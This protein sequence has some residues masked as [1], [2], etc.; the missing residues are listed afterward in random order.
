VID[1]YYPADKLVQF[2]HRIPVVFPKRTKPGG[3]AGA[4]VA[5]TDGS[6]S[7]VAAFSI[8]GEVSCFMTDFS[9]VQLVELAA[10]VRVFELFPETP[11]NL[12]TDSAYVATS[13]PLL[14]P[15][16]NIRPSTNA[17]LLFSKLPKLILARNFPFFVGHIRTHSGLLGPLSEGNDIVDQAT[18]VVAS[19]LSTTP[20]AAAQKAHDLHNLNAHTLRLKFSIT[21]EQAQ[22][23]VRQRKGCLTLLPKPHV[24]VNPHMLI[25]AELWQMDVTH[26]APFGKLKYIHGSVDTFSNFICTSLQM[27]EATKHGISHVLS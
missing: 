9:S 16:P 21:G 17:S 22:E 27:G 24:G 1:N 19:A 26:Y 4:V 15:V 6:S 14:E 25:P 7:G 8:G 18:Q 20:L 13:V 3:I 23:I 2:L 10:I 5:F 12:Y 11:F